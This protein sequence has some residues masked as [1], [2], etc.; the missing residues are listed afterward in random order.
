M[1]QRLRPSIE[2]GAEN[3]DKT[4]RKLIRKVPSVFLFTFWCLIMPGNLSDEEQALKGASV[5]DG[6]RP[7][8]IVRLSH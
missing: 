5:I 2:K 7:G 3:K 8:I 6:T 4:K 1:E